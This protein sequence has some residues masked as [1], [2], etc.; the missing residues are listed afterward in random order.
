MPAIPPRM[1]HR[2]MSSLVTHR[3]GGRVTLFNYNPS[4]AGGKIH[5]LR[6]RLAHYKGRY[7]RHHEHEH[8]VRQAESGQPVEEAVQGGVAGCPNTE[9]ESAGGRTS[10][11]SRGE[12]RKRLHGAINRAL[13]E[14]TKKRKR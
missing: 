5:I 8:I 4:I 13:K 1:H 6:H 14:S 7:L 11:R 2:P 3:T 10:R 12:E 9:Y